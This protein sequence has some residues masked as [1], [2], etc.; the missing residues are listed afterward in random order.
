MPT[1]TTSAVTD[2]AG[3]LAEWLSVIN[4]AGVVSHYADDATSTALRK[5]VTAPTTK[6]FSS[7][8]NQ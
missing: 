7:T 1:I 5:V 3:R 4:G 6:L 8:W 2:Q